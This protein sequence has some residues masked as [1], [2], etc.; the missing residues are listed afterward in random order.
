MKAHRSRCAASGP[1]QAAGGGCP[2]YVAGRSK[3]RPSRPLMSPC[4]PAEVS[5]HAKSRV[6]TR[7]IQPLRIAGK[8]QKWIGAMNASPSARR[9]F[10]AGRAHPWA[11]GRRSAR[12]YRMATCRAAPWPPA[13]AAVA[14][15]RSSSPA[16]ANPSA[17]A[18][19]DGLA[20][21]ADHRNAMARLCQWLPH[22]PII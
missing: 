7:S 6:H 13:G 9:P 22:S 17:S 11:S 3:S 4:Q 8:L 19:W 21:P 12:R 20:A 10:P 18:R 14:R 16:P 15:G 5:P 2:A 1:A